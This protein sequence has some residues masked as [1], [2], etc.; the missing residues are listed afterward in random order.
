MSGLDQTRTPAS[1]MPWENQR[2]GKVLLLAPSSPDTLGGMEHFVRE[3]A[4]GLERRGYGVEILHSGNSAPSWTNGKFGQTAR[5]VG[6]SALGYYIGRRAQMKL[7]D[8]VVAVISNSDVGYYPLR[9]KSKQTRLIQFYHGTYRGQAE[10]IRPFTKYSGYLYLK[11]WNSMVLERLSGRDKQVLVC[12]DQVGQEVRLFFGHKSTTVWYPL[13]LPRFSPRDP[14]SSR[15]ELSLPLTG[16]IGV[17][18][19]S[20][21]ATKGFPVVRK[22][23]EVFPEVYWGLALRGSAPEDLKTNPHVRIFQNMPNE[24]I[25]LLYGAADFALSPSRY[26]AF[27]YAVCEALACGSPV[28]ASPSGASCLFLKEPPL[29]RFLVSHADA[30]AEFVE[31]VRK[32]LRDP[33]FYRKAVL[34]NIRPMIEE[35]MSPEN[36]W[37]RFLEATGL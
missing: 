21:H 3:L 24:K 26:D 5:K 29:N 9:P 16:P 10:A 37:R 14:Q 27:P 32:L 30:T 31:A 6:A 19:G 28:I 4:H 15:R 18:V 11:W 23:I 25:P 22:L 33:D 2:T 20:A 7:D 34:T 35:V 17:F 12:S 36:W 13:D 1:K 8:D